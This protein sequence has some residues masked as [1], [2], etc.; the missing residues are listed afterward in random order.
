MEFIWLVAAVAVALWAMTAFELSVRYD[1]SA[2]R[3]TEILSMGGS[4]G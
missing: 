3:I 1:M 4:K 2:F